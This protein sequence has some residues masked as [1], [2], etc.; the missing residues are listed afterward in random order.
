MPVRE[1]DDNASTT[2]D[3]SPSVTLCEWAANLRSCQ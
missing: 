2:L 1:D 3:N